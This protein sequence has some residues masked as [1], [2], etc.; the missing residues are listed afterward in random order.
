MF[1]RTFELFKLYGFSVKLD[2]S[3]F[4]IAILVTWSL[5][6]GYFPQ[7]YE[8]LSQPVYWL[9]GAIGALGLFAA[10]V[11]HE[12][13]HSLMARR[14]G[15]EMSG[16]TLFIF[17]GVAEM[18]EEP[19]GAIEELKVSLAG[20]LASIG[21]S[22]AC[23]ALA[24]GGRALS[25]PVAVIGVVQYLAVINLVVVVFNMLPAFPLDGGRV[26]R[27]LIWRWQGDLRKATKWAAAVGSGFGIVLII[28]AVLSV[29]A[30]NFIGGMWLFLI[31]LFLRHAAQQSYQRILIRRALE[32]ESVRRFM[33]TEPVTVPRAASVRQLVEDYVYRYHHK[34]YPVEDRGRL[35]GCVTTRAIRELP[36]EDWDRQSVSAIATECD[37]SNT[38]APDADAMDALSTMQR[39]DASRLLVVD[40]GELVGV[41]AL[42]DLLQFFG[43]K[44]E[45]ERV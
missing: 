28:L 4:L 36:Q 22:G 31:G 44:M 32:G 42:K 39:N 1:G 17:G 37:S 23:F 6:V 16:I 2:A 3:W 38:I 12:L 15:M 35:V 19:P 40:D 25:W 11:V 34:L 41:L 24:T 33:R 13:A 18:S 14:N 30:G 45:L 7:L 43:L 26:L 29:L 21:I 8:D 27:S 5:A 20:P 10:I 9:M